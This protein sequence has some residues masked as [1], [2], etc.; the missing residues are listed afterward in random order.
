MST[1]VLPNISN[2]QTLEQTQSPMNS[3]KRSLDATTTEQPA[4][5]KVHT[6][7]AIAPRFIASRYNWQAQ[8]PH[9]VAKKDKDGKDTVQLT[10]SSKQWSYQVH[11]PPGQV[12]FCNLGEGGNIGKFN[13]CATEKSASIG[14]QYTNAP[15]NM[16]PGES[17]AD[18]NV[19]QNSFKE[20]QDKF[21]DFLR[22]TH[23]DAFQSVWENIPD[24]KASYLKKAR[25]VLPK[26]SDDAKIEAMGRKLFDKYCSTHTP[27]KED[28]QGG[29]EFQIKC[30]AFIDNKN[31][32]YSPRDVFVYDGNS[33]GFPQHETMEPG[34][35]M[36]GAIISPVFAIRV[37]QTP[38]NSAFGI[39][40]QLENRFIIF[41]KQGDGSV[42]SS[43]P[44]RDEQL[45]QRQYTF[46]GVTSKSGKYNIYVNDLNGGSYKHRIPNSA[47][48]YCDL[49]DGTLGK[50][51]GVTEDSA[52]FTIT[53]LEDDKNASYFD[54]VEALVRDAATYLFN[55][56]KI[57]KDQKAELRATAQ[58]VAAET[59]QSVDAVALSLFMENIQSPISNKGQGRELRC[60]QRMHQYRNSDDEDYVK[61]T[62][63]YRDED[64]DPMD[65]DPLLEPGCV[66]APVVYP[67]IYVLATGIIGVSMK[68]DMDNYIHVASGGMSIPEG[69]LGADVPVYSADM[70]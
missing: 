32:T 23:N 5:K 34:K 68:I 9:I 16:R 42:R 10:N 48:K 12:K 3:N 49:V 14:F 28:G 35:I 15:L 18:Y 61:N 70:F 37:Y 64:C 65:S 43:G 47:T 29:V 69:G 22:S 52:K 7:K 45:K 26:D 41:H 39:T 30:G 11:A 31:G 44:M 17:V 27:M 8:A 67:D 25:A 24:I 33:R 51:P 56:D 6:T 38:G 2:T 46:K 20:Q 55:D 53:F 36:D 13:W 19:R 66:I 1:I 40:Y 58:E 57:L 60:T 59:N 4:A 50:F 54:H 63:K 62:F 21:F